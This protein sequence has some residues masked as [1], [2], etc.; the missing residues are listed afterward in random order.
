MP[1][2]P[3]VAVVADELQFLT[4]C[5]LV[6]VNCRYDKLFRLQ[7]NL[8]LPIKI[9]CV[10]SRGKKV[11]FQTDNCLIVTSL[12]MT[13]RYAYQ[14]GEH[15]HVCLT[16]TKDNQ[17][18][19]LYYD[20]IRRFGN[21]IVYPLDAN[22]EIGP[23]LLQAAKSNI[24]LDF[25]QYVNSYLRYPNKQI[26]VALLEQKIVSGIGNYLKSEI[27]YSAQ[28]HPFRLVNS[29]TME[30][31]QKLWQY[32]HSLILYSYQCGG[33]TISDYISPSGKRG[34]YPPLV[35]GK[36]IDNFGRTILKENDKNGRSTF[37]VA[38]N[39]FT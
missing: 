15:T 3:E 8:N 4:D 16:F 20:D 14:V 5:Y 21:I 36:N 32:S 2:G 6:N 34:N 18:F 25:S 12:G 9:N 28:I 23:D 39:L 26:A 7:T 33:L 35:Y 19:A 30:E 10:Y 27:L 38:E 31:W 1:E 24:Y 37:W 22:L 13:G 29:L 11:I 17:S